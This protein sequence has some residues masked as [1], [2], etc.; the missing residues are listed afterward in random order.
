MTLKLSRYALAVLESLGQRDCSQL[1][2][3]F[4]GTDSTFRIGDQ[5]T[6]EF[7]FRGRERFIFGP[8][9]DNFMYSVVGSKTNLYTILHV[10]PCTILCLLNETFYRY[11]H[12]WSHTEGVYRI[13][14]E[15]EI[16][17]LFRPDPFQE[18]MRQRTF[19]ILVEKANEIKDPSK[20]RWDPER[21]VFVIM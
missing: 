13:N 15:N 12:P 8:H 2:G 7:E 9:D 16:T 3:Q 19:E 5:Y 6:R 20:I 11:E 17:C 1:V 18:I 14:Q 21:T 4:L 10:T